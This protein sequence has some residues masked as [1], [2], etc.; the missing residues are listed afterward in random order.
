[1]EEAPFPQ[2]YQQ[3]QAKAV[4]GCPFG[5]HRWTLHMSEHG[6]AWIQAHAETL[7]AVPAP[8]HVQKS[9]PPIV[10]VLTAVTAFPGNVDQ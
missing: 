3:S 4:L 5:Q 9:Y 1:M 6:F 7:C 2:V 10:T 8:E